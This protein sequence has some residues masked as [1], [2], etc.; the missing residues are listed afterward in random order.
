MSVRG[1]Q[2]IG[3]GM[4]GP[5]VPSFTA[6]AVFGIAFHGDDPVAR[7]AVDKANVGDAPQCGV[8]DAK[9]VAL[10]GCWRMPAPCP[11][12]AAGGKQCWTPRVTRLWI[13]GFSEAP[14]YEG[15]T[16]RVAFS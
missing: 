11:Y 14:A 3:E 5:D 6:Y 2:P 12:R 4:D 1:A 13:S 15:G 7:G 9:H 10:L 16:P 8:V